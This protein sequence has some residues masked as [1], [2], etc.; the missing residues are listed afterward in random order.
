MD[1]LQ[2]SPQ[3]AKTSG[4]ATAGSVPDPVVRFDSV[5]KSYGSVQAVRD[6]SFEVQRGEVMGLL[7][8]NGAGKTTLIRILLDIIRA[9]SGSVEVFGELFRR[10]HLD[11]IVYL[12]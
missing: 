4:A 6:V 11:R 3:Q 12:P 5:S 9:T 2:H 7:G 8:P 10:E 1:D